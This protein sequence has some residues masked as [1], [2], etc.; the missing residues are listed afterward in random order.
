MAAKP[1]PLETGLIGRP[2]GQAFPSD[3]T[4][5]LGEQAAPMP[6]APE[7]SLAIAPQGEPR[8]GLTIRI[9]VSDA[10]RLHALAS[11]TRWKK[12]ALLDQAIREFLDRHDDMT[13][14]L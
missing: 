14:P 1:A 4:V 9:R 6:E 13:K 10:D 3:A 2:K 7:A 11:R 12:Q 8:T 5:G